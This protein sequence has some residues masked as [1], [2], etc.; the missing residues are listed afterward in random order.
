MGKQIGLSW[1]TT[2]VL[3]ALFTSKIEAKCF[4][5]Q[6]HITLGNYFTESKDTSNYY[7]IS[8]VIKTS[9]DKKCMPELEVEGDQGVKIIINYS[10]TTV[11]VNKDKEYEAIAFFFSVSK[12]IADTTQKWRVKTSDAKTSWHDFS[13]IDRSN[14]KSKFLI[15]ADMSTCKMSKPLYSKFAEISS[16]E[17]DAFMHV[18]DFAYSVHNNKGKVGDE[19]FQD[20]TSLIT[21]RIPYIVTPGNHEVDYKGEFF[22]YRFQ[23]PG[24]GDPLKRASHWY[25][26]DYKG[27]HW[28]SLNFDYIFDINP[29]KQQEAFNWLQK[30]LEKASKDP[31]VNFIIFFSHRP[32]YC[33][34]KDSCD[35]FFLALPYES[36]L[37]KYKVDIII[38]GHAHQYMR[39]VP[40]NSFK[41]VPK[42]Q[43]PLML[44]N[45]IGGSLSSSTDPKHKGMK[46]PFAAV[47][48]KEN[49]GYMVLEADQDQVK[50]EVFE[51]VGGSLI[52]S[53]ITQRRRK[54]VYIF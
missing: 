46:G 1:R 50:I 36:L 42:A 51:A 53:F 37:R 47:A 15:V 4:A 33:E 27:V 8:S 30:D 24:G 28:T 21:S 11:Y 52:D 6:E 12:N 3:L 41:L 10:S 49:A 43:S 23:M 16:S 32:F 48:Y 39:L 5:E 18:G 40:N 7:T 20:M 22:S 19:F 31:R 17:Y 35:M 14:S 45:G 13:M 2:V 34:K 9:V 38:S 29:D 54:G 26:F 44:I 25:S